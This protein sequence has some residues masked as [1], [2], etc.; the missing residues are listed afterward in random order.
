MASVSVITSN[1]VQNNFAIKATSIHKDTKRL[2]N[3]ARKHPKV[4][5]LLP[6]CGRKIGQLPFLPSLMYM[7]FDQT[8]LDDTDDQVCKVLHILLNFTPLCE[9]Y[10]MYSPR[11]SCQYIQSDLQ[12]HIAQPDS[13]IR[14]SRPH[15]TQYCCGYCKLEYLWR[16]S[17]ATALHGSTCRSS[18]RVS[19]AYP[20]GYSYTAKLL[21]NQSPIRH[22]YY[23]VTGQSQCSDCLASGWWNRSFAVYL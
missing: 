22:S 2:T 15:V 5:K 21:F 16:Y 18:C 23:T 20:H 1:C 14:L 19:S 17:A 13:S 12:N 3:L 9:I 10:H 11:K 8:R 6:T 7:H 4:Q